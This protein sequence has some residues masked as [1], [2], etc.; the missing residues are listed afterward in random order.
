MACSKKKKKP[1]KLIKRRKNRAG[2]RKS[3]SFYVIDNVVTPI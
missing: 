1:A 3:N 2:S